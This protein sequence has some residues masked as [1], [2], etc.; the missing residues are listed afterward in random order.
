MAKTTTAKASKTSKPTTPKKP[1]RAKRP[2]GERITLADLGDDR[3]P[4]D[5]FIAETPAPPDVEATALTLH[6]DTPSEATEVQAE[7]APEAPDAGGCVDAGEAT[8]PPRRRRQPRVPAKA[9]RGA[10]AALCALCTHRHQHVATYLRR[11]TK[12]YRPGYI[13]D[14][15]VEWLVAHARAAGH[16]ALAAESE[17]EAQ[18]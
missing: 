1:S 6:I 13:T 3:A 2:T 12:T 5:V 16:D 14:A 9:Q 10:V 4:W 7:A 11:W 18:S 17:A 15:D 8:A